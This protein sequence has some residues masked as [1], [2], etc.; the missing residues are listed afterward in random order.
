MVSAVAAAASY[1]RRGRGGHHSGQQQ[2]PCLQTASLSTNNT[3]RDNPT[4]HFTSGATLLLGRGG[5]VRS[6][7]DDYSSPP[8]ARSL[9]FDETPASMGNSVSSLSQ[10]QSTRSAKRCAA[11]DAWDDALRKPARHKKDALGT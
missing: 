11:E 6:H 2:S 10:S 3:V 1:S 4:V 8:P 9:N 7:Y 5:G